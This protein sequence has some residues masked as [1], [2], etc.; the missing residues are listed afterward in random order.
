MY[1]LKSVLTCGQ[2]FTG[3]YIHVASTSQSM[4]QASNDRLQVST[5]GSQVADT[6]NTLRLSELDTAESLYTA[7][8]PSG[9][10]QKSRRVHAEVYMNVNSGVRGKSY[11]ELCNNS[12]YIWF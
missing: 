5:S 8:T 12:L 1:N 6:Y 2:T 9:L 3:K 11:M 10:F 4:S 7:P